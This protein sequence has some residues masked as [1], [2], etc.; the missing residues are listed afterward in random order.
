MKLVLEV[1]GREGQKPRTGSQA[2]PLEA[3]EVLKRSLL[4]GADWEEEVTSLPLSFQACSL[5]SAA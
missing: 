3:T 4:R 5:C 2:P 1:W